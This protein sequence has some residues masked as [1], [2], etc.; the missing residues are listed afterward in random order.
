ME[1]LTFSYKNA[2]YRAASDKMEIIQRSIRRLR[3]QLEAYIAGRP[4]FLR[5]MEPPANPPE[6]NAPEIVRLMDKAA[7]KTGVG[8]MAAVAGAIAEAAAAAALSA[9]AEHAVVDNG[10]DI[11]IGA[12]P[13]TAAF[14]Y[15]VGLFPFSPGGAP[16]SPLRELAFAICR[17]DLP[18]AI[19]SSSSKMGHSLSFGDCDLAVVFS[20]D[21]AL[22]DAAAT[23]ACNR[24]KDIKEVDAALE[25]TVS[26]A[27]IR[28]VVIIKDGHLGMAGN[29]PDLVRH[30]DPDLSGKVTRSPESNFPG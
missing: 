27:G 20:T 29:V 12:I 16:P 23:A 11:Y 6:V 13:A 22:A 10:G 4:V 15:L 8:P 9:G 2:H 3:G 21:A 30:N 14:P 5:A 18:L 7:R 19:C 1:F 28:G 25:R 17:E 24:V 26:I